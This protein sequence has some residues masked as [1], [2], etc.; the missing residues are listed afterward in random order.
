MEPDKLISVTSVVSMSWCERK[1]AF[2]ENFRFPGDNIDTL[3]GTLAHD[4]ICQVS[5]STLVY[6]YSLSCAWLI[7]LFFDT[8]H[9]EKV[10]WN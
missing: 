3:R 2:S 4:L 1:V 9:V 7:M 6:E 10:V 5:N 8:G